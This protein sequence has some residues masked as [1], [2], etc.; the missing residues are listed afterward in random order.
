MASAIASDYGVLRRHGRKKPLRNTELPPWHQ[1]GYRSEAARAT[2]WIES[3]LTVPTGYRQGSKMKLAKFH[4]EIVKTVYGNY[5]S[6]FS[7]PT[8]NGK[9]TLFAAL[10]IER[11]CRGDSYVKVDVVAT[12]RDQARKLLNI[13][14]QFIEQHPLLAEL[15]VLYSHDGI[16]EYR[17]TGSRIEVHPANVTALQGLN[18]NLGLVDEIG[19]AKPET[20]E[21]LMPRL[22]KQSSGRVAC[23]GTPGYDEGDSLLKRFHD[24]AR[25]GTLPAE[26]GYLEWSAP[27]GCALDDWP[28]VEKANPAL[29][30][31]LMNRD[32]LAVMASTLSEHE[33]RM[34]HLGQWIGSASGW[35][36]PGA[37]EDCP[38]AAPPPAGTDVVLAVDGSYRRQSAIC[39][40]TLDGAVFFV[41][42][43]SGSEASDTKLRAELD[44]AIGHWNVVELAYN[45][46]VRVGFFAE[47]E[48]EG[49]PVQPW[50]GRG[51]EDAKSTS[52]LY[53]AI[54]SREVAHDHDEFLAE[55]M[56]RLLAR[57][58]HY[59][60]LKLAR[61]GDFDVSAAMAARSAWWRAKALAPDLTAEPSVI[62]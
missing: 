26:I 1:W 6:A 54:E 47:L 62:W 48:R 8:G 23:F 15:C 32:G 46:H 51:D 10:A 24:Q 25:D 37:W 61:P 55:Q 29:A 41:W 57:P 13:V 9:T 18:Y 14:E 43:A 36:P 53:R 39:G 28:A 22:V 42:A 21:A 19:F 31:G 16:I 2:R 38:L 45:P 50:V 40:C 7:I 49:L 5:I 58:D 17:P 11:V 33:F 60:L 4:R 3:E 59:G 44:A 30:A 12:K 52:D 35:L 27:E 34:Y 20:V 56:G